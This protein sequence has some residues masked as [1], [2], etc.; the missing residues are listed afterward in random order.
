MRLPPPPINPPFMGYVYGAQNVVTG[1][2]Q[3]IPLQPMPRPPFFGS[4]FPF[5]APQPPNAAQLAAQK[6]LEKKKKKKK[7]QTPGI[8]T[9]YAKHP[10]GIFRLLVIVS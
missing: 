10:L 9:N 1:P 2:P 7:I 5:G 3:V 4:P 8:N 6:K